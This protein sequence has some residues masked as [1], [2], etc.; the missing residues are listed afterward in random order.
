MSSELPYSRTGTP[1][2]ASSSFVAVGRKG[3]GHPKIGLEEL[4]TRNRFSSLADESQEECD[5]SITPPAASCEIPYSPASPRVSSSVLTFG[6][7]GARQHVQPKNGL[8]VFPIQN[9]FAPLAEECSG[10]NGRDNRDGRGGRDDGGGRKL[11]HGGGGEPAPY[12][13]LCSCGKEYLICKRSGSALRPAVQKNASSGNIRVNV[14][15]G[16]I[17]GTRQKSYVHQKS[18]AITS[19][20]S[21]A[22]AK[23]TLHSS[24]MY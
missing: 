24:R 2:R 18:C 16:Q 15:T 8:E 1:P 12:R 22:L 19:K 11:L 23:K 7:K 14:M 3:A 21:K 13:R 5:S 17:Y 4:P 10:R 6:R 9:R 20:T